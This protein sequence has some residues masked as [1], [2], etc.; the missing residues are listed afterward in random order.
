M[1]NVEESKNECCD[2]DIDTN[3]ASQTQMNLVTACL[4]AQIQHK[5]FT[6]KSAVNDPC[7]K[8]NVVVFW[9][10]QFWLYDQ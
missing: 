3:M 5:T 8:V 1:M 4:N 10:T 6:S 2:K 7:M 9:H